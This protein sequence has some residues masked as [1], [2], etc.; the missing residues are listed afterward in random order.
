V[1]DRAPR[2]ERGSAMVVVMVILV[3]LSMAGSMAIYL[4]LSDTRASG[5]VRRAA[6]RR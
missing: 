4:Q 1:I 6:F 3:A 5:Y 2:G